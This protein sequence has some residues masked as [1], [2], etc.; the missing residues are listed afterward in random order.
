MSR[1]RENKILIKPT[2]PS[3]LWDKYLPT[4]HRTVEE[5]NENNKVS[6][7]G[8]EYPKIRVT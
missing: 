8:Y 7:K 3:T 6:F 2:S 1:P 4:L 5:R